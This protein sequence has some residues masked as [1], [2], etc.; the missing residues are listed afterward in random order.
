MNVKKKKKGDRRGAY[1]SGGIPLFRV[2]GHEE[3]PAEE[4]E[5]EHPL[6]KVPEASEG[7]VSR[8]REQST[9]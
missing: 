5:K 7:S 2:W 9:V 4:I 8:K 1:S 3:E 6:R